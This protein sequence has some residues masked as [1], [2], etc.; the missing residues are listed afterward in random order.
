MPTSRMLLLPPLLGLVVM[1]L[2]STACSGPKLAATPAASA[3]WMEQT[4]QTTLYTV[5]VRTGPAVTLEAMHP[6]AVMTMVDQG[7]AV[8]HHL[9]VHLF[10]KTTGAELKNLIPTVTIIEQATGT[11]YGLPNVEACLRANHRVGEPHYGDNL[12]LPDGRYTLTINVGGE[13]ARLQ[14]SL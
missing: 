8:N 7:R 3:E 5:K 14:L 1:L 13:T 9:E 6:G 4:T 2:S 11:S 12:Y 10:D